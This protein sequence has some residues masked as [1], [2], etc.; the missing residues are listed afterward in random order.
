MARPHYA[1]SVSVLVK[2]LKDP[3][4][5]VRAEV[6][7]EL[8]LR[9]PD[10]S[11]AVELLIRAAGYDESSGVRAC[12]VTALTRLAQDDVEVIKPLEIHERAADYP[13]SAMLTFARERVEVALG[14]R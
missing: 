3:D 2:R 12:A 4:E 1:C 7:V 11:G 5:I 13:A 9:G 6:A 8:G 14:P 10:A